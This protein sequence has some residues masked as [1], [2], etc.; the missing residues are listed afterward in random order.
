MYLSPP[1]NFLST[2]VLRPPV[3]VRRIA[4]AR[5]ILST[6]DARLS[7]G[8]HQISAVFGS[9]T[10]LSGLMMALWRVTQPDEGDHQAGS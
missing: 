4:D 7:T 6:P 2:V 5:D 9:L 3:V 8:Y 1:A 10:T